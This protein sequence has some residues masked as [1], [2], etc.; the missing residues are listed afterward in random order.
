MH[1]A[2]INTEIGWLCLKGNGEALQKLDIVDAVPK[3]LPEPEPYLKDIANQLEEYFA[4]KRRVFTFKMTPVGTAFQL[5]VWMLLIEVPY[6]HSTTYKNIALQLGDEKKVR[7]VGQA[8]G[9][10]PIAIAIPCHRV[11][12]VDGGLTGFA[13][14]LHKKKRLLELEGFKDLNTRQSELLF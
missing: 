9:K 6:G 14:G 13:W 5:K 8:I 2:Y 7:A 3:R 4:K 10:N 1:I 12:G 11:V